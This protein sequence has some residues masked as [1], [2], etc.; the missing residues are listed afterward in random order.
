MSG[1]CHVARPMPIRQNTSGSCTSLDVMTMRPPG[2]SSPFR[3]STIRKWAR[4]LTAKASSRPSADDR[5]PVTV[6]MPALSAIA[7]IGRG[8][9]RRTT[10]SH[11]R[12]TEARLARSAST[13]ASRSAA[14]GS[15]FS[16]STRS[17]GRASRMTVQFGRSLSSVLQGAAA[18]AARPACHH[19]AL[20]RG[21][22]PLAPG[23]RPAAS[24]CVMLER[25][26]GVPR[27]SRT[28]AD[29]SSIARRYCAS[30][31]RAKLQSGGL[32]G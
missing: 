13:T 28:R 20:L 31:R 7:S 6:W 3:R 15:A 8:P 23:R 5:S 24:S 21:A 18:D 16:S 12:S 32:A 25:P 19:Q 2:R 26:L 9:S 30:S 27:S 11:A 4:K 29:A 17:D 10:S 14:P 1:S 22:E